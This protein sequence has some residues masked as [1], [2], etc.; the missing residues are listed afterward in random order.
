MKVKNYGQIYKLLEFI[1]ILQFSQ[2]HLTFEIYIAK[3]IKKWLQKLLM[4][5]NVLYLV[6]FL[7]ATNTLQEHH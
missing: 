7:W 1:G 5:L 2:I 6:H 4:K 3:E